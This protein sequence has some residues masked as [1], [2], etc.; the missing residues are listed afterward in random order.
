M[1]S[2]DASEQAV[3]VMA[4]LLLI[5]PAKG[6]LLGGLARILLPV[7]H[8]LQELLRLFL[9][10]EGKPCKA[11]F[12]LEGVKEDAILVVVPRIVDL[13]VPYNSSITGLQLTCQ[14]R[15][16]YDIMDGVLFL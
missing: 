10:D 9:V 1:S 12:E 8:L 4:A 3:L 6:R 13:L 14:L 11:F 7:V 15:R 5:R 2:K 16:E